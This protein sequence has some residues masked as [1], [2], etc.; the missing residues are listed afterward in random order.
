MP[1]IKEKALKEM[2]SG[3]TLIVNSFPI[4]HKTTEIIDIPD[5]Q[6]DRSGTLYVYRF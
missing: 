1:K 3:Q 2:K 4:E 6:Q 5:Y